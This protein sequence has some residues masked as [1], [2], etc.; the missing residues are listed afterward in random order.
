MRVRRIDSVVLFG[1][2]TLAG[3]HTRLDAVEVTP[4][5]FHVYDAF[6]ARADIVQLY[7]DGRG[8]VI[9]EYR[10]DGEVFAEASLSSYEL[11][12]LADL[13]PPKNIDA[14]TARM[15]ARGAVSRGRRAED[16]IH[17]A[18]RLAVWDAELIAKFEAARKSGKPMQL[19]AGYELDLDP[20]PGE[21]ADG[22][23]Y[24]AI[25]RNIR[26][27]HV[28]A[29]PL[30]RAG[31][32]RVLDDANALADAWSLERAKS[33]SEI[34]PH[35]GR[36]TF[37]MGGWCHHDAA[38]VLEQH[39]DDTH[40]DS[41]TMKKIKIKIDGKDV[42]IQVAADAS[43]EQIA[44]AVTKAHADAAKLHADA[45]A[46]AIEQ[47]RKDAEAKVRD[48]YAMFGKKKSEEEDAETKAKADAAHKAELDKVRK[49]AAE[50]AELLA[51]GK[52]VLGLRFDAAG[53]DDN[54]IR[55]AVIER[56]SGEAVRK[57]AEANPGAIPYLYGK[58][59]EQHADAPDHS[60]VLLDEIRK[61][62]ADSRKDADGKPGPITQARRDA[63]EQARL[64]RH[65][66]DTAT[67]KAAG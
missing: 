17:V 29:V 47:A 33:L 12:P 16:G 18:G 25:Q 23:R 7:D 24:D 26:I 41:N 67:Q 64:P 57:D 52:A 37:D 34:A 65:Q 39:H 10:P 2:V 40:T 28:A 5:G 31:T 22:R 35:R 9:R 20:T 8:G 21:L 36:V 51:S 66:R 3:V 1:A 59:L 54:G 58:A 42:E 56:V 63:E 27:N 19:S 50:R 32:A 48:E 46:K 53:L 44:A 38:D 14:K 15:L 45:H 30:G 60:A 11:R 55:L 62:A 6:F 13:H 43:P 61:S 4:E 49:D